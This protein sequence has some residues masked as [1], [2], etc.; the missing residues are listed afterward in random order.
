MSET[1]SNKRATSSDRAGRWYWR[2]LRFP[3]VI[4]LVGGPLVFICGYLPFDILL[5]IQ[6]TTRKG[7]SASQTLLGTLVALPSAALAYWAIARG[8]ERRRPDELALRRA[9]RELSL[10]I[11]IGIGLLSLIVGVIAILGGYRVTGIH[12]PAVLI[13]PIAA[14]ILASFVEELVVRGILFRVAQASLGTWLATLISAGIFGLLHAGNPNATVVSTLAIAVS[15]GTVL[16]GAYVMTGRLWACI[17]M[18]FAANAAQAG[19][20]GLPV[21]GRAAAGLLDSELSGPVLISGGEFGLEASVV[22][23]VAAAAL[24]VVFFT[25]AARRNRIVPPFWRRP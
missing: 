24:S 14:A 12:G 6:D 8:I 23:V 19:V 25:V 2:V 15:A 1:E 22:T 20:F 9:G 7:A 16:A 18:H 10:G 4:I 11:A 17:G 21:S 3:M 5:A 13:V